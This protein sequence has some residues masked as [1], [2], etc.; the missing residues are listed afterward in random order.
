MII[1]VN[2]RMLVKDKM[3]GIGYFTYESMK[4]ITKQQSGHEFIFLFDRPYDPSF[5]FSDNI[6][7]IVVSP[8]A[9]HPILWYLWFEQ[10]LP[11][12]FKKIKADLFL[13]TDGYLS[14]ASG[15][16]TLAVIHDINFEHYPKDLPFFNR[17]Y[18]RHYF[19]KYAKQAARI[20]TVSEY[21]R[22]DIVKAYNV[23]ESKIDVVYN[24]AG[25]HFAPLNDEQI[26]AVRNKY[27]QG[28]PYFLFTGALH[29]RKNIANLMRAFDLF[30]Q[31]SQEKF[32]LVLAGTKRWWTSEMESVYSGMKFREDVV[33]TGRLTEDELIAVSGAAY[34]ITYVSNFEGFGIPIVE[35]FR[36][37]VPVIT[38]NITSMPE[39]AGDAAIL[40]DPFSENS[41]ADGMTRLAGDPALRMQLI[42]KGRVRKSSFSWDKTADSLWASVE[43]TI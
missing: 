17:V 8:P 36:C 32:Y 30:R 25:E 10:S 21:S 11:R 13:S 40:V 5:I 2:A 34:A 42:E 29:Q 22:Q 31:Q 33:F 16:K 26:S 35:A 1:A 28:K 27:T 20:A 38:S 15:Q 23:P 4:R 7:P 18:Y 37:D 9:R 6:T 41:I 39:I 3:E 24:G 14:L 43:K 19:P 12:V